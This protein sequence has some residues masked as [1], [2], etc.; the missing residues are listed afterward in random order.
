VGST[1]A[2]PTKAG[3][4][5][6]INAACVLLL[7]PL[8]NR[9]GRDAVDD[10]VVRDVFGDY[11]AHPNHGSPNRYAIECTRPEDALALIYERYS[12]MSEP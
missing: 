10:C 8:P 5:L 12:G 9:F 7:R 6:L 11:C 4:Q 3:T 1:V 2:A